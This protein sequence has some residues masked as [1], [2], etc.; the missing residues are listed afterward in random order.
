MFSN[1]K[2]VTPNLQGQ[3]RARN[4]RIPLCTELGYCKSYLVRE[5]VRKKSKS[6]ELRMQLC[7]SLSSLIL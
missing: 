3:M 7:F 4:F 6:N 1:I 2:I 5:E